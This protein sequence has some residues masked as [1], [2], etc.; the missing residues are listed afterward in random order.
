MKQH[1]EDF[2]EDLKKTHGD[3]LRSVILY[4]S[5]ATGEFKPFESNYNLLVALERIT[6]EDLRNSHSAVREWVRLGH[7]V[8]T[9]FTVEE[10]IDSG[11]VFPIE[12]HFMERARKVLYG[13]D[14][15]AHVEIS[16]ENLRHQLEY[17]LRSN[18]L[19]LRKRYI[20]VSTDGGRLA[21]LMSASIA[22]FAA[23]FRAVL[24]LKGAEPP[25][26]KREILK[27][28]ASAVGI[29]GSSFEKVLA[30]RENGSKERMD[31]IAANELFAEYLEDIE[32]VIAAVNVL[33]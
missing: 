15:L 7:P 5:A 26:S 29:A 22:S 13:E 1:F 21:E 14:V 20:E 25:V 28:T 33:E 24:L 23:D 3:N 32:S 27:E 31:V 2:I 30:I 4:G 10:L 16:D 19:R 9:Y 6:P 18:L 12:L 17:E 11:D 8:P